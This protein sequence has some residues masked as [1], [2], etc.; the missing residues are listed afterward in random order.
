MLRGPGYVE[1]GSHR[2]EQE[3][4]LRPPSPRLGGKDHLRTRRTSSSN[5]ID[6]DS[7]VG[8]DLDPNEVHEAAE[9]AALL[10]PQQSEADQ[11][12]DA[13]TVE[14]EHFVQKAAVVAGFDA[15]EAHPGRT[16]LPE[17]GLLTAKADGS[18]RFCRKVRFALLRRGSSSPRRASHSVM[19]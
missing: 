6:R 10:L 3:V 11:R 4:G 8:S 2:N 16:R 1:K 13:A 7:G 14:L 15:E 18:V 19:P 9:H 12:R 5:S 17:D